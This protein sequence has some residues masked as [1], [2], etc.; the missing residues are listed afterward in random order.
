MSFKAHIRAVEIY[1]ENMDEISHKMLRRDLRN[2]ASARIVYIYLNSSKGKLWHAKNIAVELDAFQRAFEGEV[3]VVGTQVEGL[4]FYPFLAFPFFNRLAMRSSVFVVRDSSMG[5]YSVDSSTPFDEARRVLEQ[6]RVL[7]SDFSKLF[8][9]TKIDERTLRQIV[10][11]GESIEY[12]GEK[13]KEY[14]LAAMFIEEIAA[15]G[16]R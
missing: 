7:I 9:D 4:A 6:R 2:L 10:Q 11:G 8:S 3:N 5:I 12:K 13:I 1:I 15:Q 16:E 14:G